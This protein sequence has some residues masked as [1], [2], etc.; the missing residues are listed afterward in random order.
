MPGTFFKKIGVNY[1]RDAKRAKEM[2]IALSIGQKE[3][4][5]IRESCRSLYDMSRIA[6]DGG[7]SWTIETAI[8]YLEKGKI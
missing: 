3:D 7:F 6:E 8:R 5:A 2:F 4:W 1:G